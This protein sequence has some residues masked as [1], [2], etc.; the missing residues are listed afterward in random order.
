VTTPRRNSIDLHTHSSRSDGILSPTE[1]YAQMRDY[2]MRLV[3]LSD[4]DTLDGYRELR[5]RGLGTAESPGG[6]R[7]VPAVEINT[8]AGDSGLDWPGEVHILGYGLNI[9]DRGFE[10]T[11]DRQRELRRI[12][13]GDA[14]RALGRLGMPIDDVIDSVTPADPRASIGRPHLAQALVVKGYASSVE[15]AFARIL[16][17]GRAGYVPRFGIDT[18]QAI[19]AIRAA[20]GLA[21]LAHFREALEH[22]EVLDR[23]TDWGVGGL[24]VY[25][26]GGHHGFDSGQVGAMAALAR[27]RDLVATGGSDYH[28]HAMEDARPIA[29]A[30]AQAVTYV[31]PEVGDAFLEA[32]GQTSASAA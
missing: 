23:L 14:V 4:H 7:V 25:Y 31:P 2:G 8:L 16:Q 18:R 30:E 1:L 11:L 22:A 32:L 5:G 27:E 24:E 29:Y 3:A 17:V 15:D 6:P 10:A 20:G 21:V 26:G 13:F 9:D 19:D 28:G 12:R